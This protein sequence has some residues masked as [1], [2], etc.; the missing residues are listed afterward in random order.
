VAAIDL[1]ARWGLYA[2]NVHRGLVGPLKDLDR[3]MGELDHL[4]HA[5]RS[6]VRLY[7]RPRLDTW[8]FRLVQW[9]SGTT[10]LSIRDLDSA[11]QTLDLAPQQR[12]NLEEARTLLQQRSK[13]RGCTPEGR[14]VWHV[15][16]TASD[17]VGRFYA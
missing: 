15:A 17:T 9:H 10:Y 8:E 1:Q 7:Q 13:L 14:T 3:R 11:F 4:L 5:Q 12:S 16:S 2:E 6:A